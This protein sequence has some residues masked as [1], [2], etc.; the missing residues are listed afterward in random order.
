MANQKA[1]EQYNP[2]W[3]G[4]QIPERFRFET[5]RRLLGQLIQEID[6]DKIN[7][8]VGLR[9][10]GKS[11]LLYQIMMQQECRH[12]GIKMTYNLKQNFTELIFEIVQA[13]TS[14]QREVLAMLRA[15]PMSSKEISERLGLTRLAVLMHLNGLQQ[16][17]M[18][19]KK[20][21]GRRITYF[22][23]NL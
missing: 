10:V 21:K 18:A 5:K 2:W 13:L 20:R 7:L 23:L 12:S 19:V 6:Q 9:R 16:K 11:V 8:V 15:K 22:A 1:Y 3:Q 14:R 4:Q 17:N